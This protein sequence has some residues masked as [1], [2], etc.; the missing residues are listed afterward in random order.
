MGVSSNRWIS[1]HVIHWIIPP[2]MFRIPSAEKMTHIW[3]SNSTA[4]M[5]LTWLKFQVG[6]SNSVA[7]WTSKCYSRPPIGLNSSQFCSRYYSLYWAYSPCAD[8]HKLLLVK[9]CFF[10]NK[11]VNILNTQVLSHSARQTRLLWLLK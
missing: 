11:F 8:H 6:I 4:E 3:F 7:S 5:Q 9:S 10:C 2:S 1:I